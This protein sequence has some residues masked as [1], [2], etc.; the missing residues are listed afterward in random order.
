MSTRRA[1]QHQYLV[2][3]EKKYHHRAGAHLHQH[4]KTRWVSL[5][6]AIFA[7][8]PDDWL[9]RAKQY[10]EFEQEWNDRFYSGRFWKCP[11]CGFVNVSEE[12]ITDWAV[13]KCHRCKKIILIIMKPYKVGG[14]DDD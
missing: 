4:Y 12:N 14:L 13:K 9:T 3:L 6:D 5:I 11:E 10:S 7:E 8:S 1:K 2:A